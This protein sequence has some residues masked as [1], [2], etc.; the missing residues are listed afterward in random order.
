[1]FTAEVAVKN[2]FLHIDV[3]DC[4]KPAAARRSH[5]APALRSGKAA[6][7]DDDVDFSLKQEEQAD[8]STEASTEDPLSEEEGSLPSGSSSPRQ[9]VQRTPL[10]SQARA[11]RPPQKHYSA[12]LLVPNPMQAGYLAAKFLSRLQAVAAALAAAMAGHVENAFVEEGPC[13][14]RVVLRA[15]KE[16]LDSLELAQQSLATATKAGEMCV[17]GGSLQWSASGFSVKLA[18]VPDPSR[19]CWGMYSHGCCRRGMACQWQH[20]ER[21]A[22]LEVVVESS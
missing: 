10:S 6:D 3:Q 1:M 2:T 11:F 21:S 8:A 19:A 17:L 13:G 5:S 4:E 12:V 7:E 9:D 22:Y 20:P 14:V 18:E 16:S 15:K